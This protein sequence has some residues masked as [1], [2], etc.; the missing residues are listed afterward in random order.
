MVPT[1][2]MWLSINKLI[3]TFNSILSTGF[4]VLASFLF[5]FFLWYIIDHRL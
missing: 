2:L 4:V 3:P 5:D 1:S